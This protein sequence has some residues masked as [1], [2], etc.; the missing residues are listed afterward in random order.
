MHW[1]YVLKC[2]DGHIYVGQTQRLFSRFIE[3][4]SNKVLNTG[5]YRPYALIG[6]Y[7]VGPNVSFMEYHQN[8]INPKL[9]YNPNILA[10]WEDDTKPYYMVENLITERYMYEKVEDW[11]K[12]RGGKYTNVM[13]DIE[14]IC[15]PWSKQY[16]YKKLK[17]NVILDRPLC[18]CG[19]P[20]EVIKT[21][22]NNV[23]FKC[24]LDVKKEQWLSDSISLHIPESCNYFQ[25]YTKDAIKK[26]KY[27]A[28]ESLFHEYLQEEWADN[29]PIIQKRH[30]YEQQY[31]CLK[32]KKKK[33]FAVYV[34]KYYRQLCKHC[35][36]KHHDE[37]SKKF[38]HRIKYE[39]LEDKSSEDISE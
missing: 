22:N 30:C 16:Y 38:I 7:R 12:V 10:D 39:F 19:Y 9:E 36:I 34:N 3:H 32:C 27:I 8:S 1:V 5:V 26:Q 33:Y 20:C 35:M 13:D 29:L 23:M 25:P 31:S 17:A 28:R 4:I 37:L 2:E 18:H 6:L 11:W 21:K 24:P 14:K 15:L